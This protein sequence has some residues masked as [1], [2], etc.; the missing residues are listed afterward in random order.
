MSYEFE[1]RACGIPC[2]I[3][4]LTWDAYRPAVIRADPGDSHPAEGG[5]GE[6]ELLDSRG[7]PAPWLERKLTPAERE[8]ID[9]LVY[10]KME[11]YRED[12]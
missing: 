10:E 9:A 4:V 8:R 11:N 2:T 5:E 7:R 3:R 1:A 6:W 12:Y